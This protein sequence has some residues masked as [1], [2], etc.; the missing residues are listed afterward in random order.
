MKRKLFVFSLFAAAAIALVAG[1]AFAQG[2]GGRGGRPGGGFGG[3]GFGGRGGGPGAG[4]GGGNQII[5]LLMIEKVREEVSLDDDQAAAL[6]KVREDSQSERPDFDFRNASEEERSKF[7]EKMQKERAEQAS[8]VQ[9]QIEQVLLPDQMDRLKEISLQVRGVMALSDPDVQSELGITSEQKEKL[10]SVRNSAQEGMRDKMRDMRDLFQSGDS[11]K[12]QEA[13]AK[14]RKEI[15]GKVMDVLT[16]EQ[17]SKFEK[18][19]G[20]PFEMPEDFRGGGF[21][22]RRSGG[23]GPGADGGG[24]PSGGRQGGGRQG[25]GR[26]GG[27]GTGNRPG[28]EAPEGN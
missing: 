6:K 16:G 2:G 7:F 25:G 4:P 23:G 17:K 28:Q 12:I 26:Q 22:G 18:M 27:R 3:G 11:E 5:G 14:V 9:S 8:K 19:K 1:D 21:M 20:E 15:D 24:R 13:V 10:E